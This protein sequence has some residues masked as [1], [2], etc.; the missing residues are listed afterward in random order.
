MI[1]PARKMG[2]ENNNQRKESVNSEKFE[3]SNNS[4]EYGA[5]MQR[6]HMDW[7]SQ[8]GADEENSDLY[9]VIN[10]KCDNSFAGI[11]GVNKN[12]AGYDNGVL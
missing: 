8:V 11:K 6:K 7:E 2:N 12:A 3:K 1:R 4:E 9:M 10:D 5:N